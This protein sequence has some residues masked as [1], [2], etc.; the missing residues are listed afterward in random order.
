[1]KYPL[2]SVSEIRSRLQSISDCISGDP[3]HNQR[4]MGDFPH[5]ILN[6]PKIK[7]SIDPTEVLIRNQ[8]SEPI[9][10]FFELSP[11]ANVSDIKRY[12]SDKAGG[13][14]ETLFKIMG[15]D[16]LGW[17][18]PFHNITAQHGIYISSAGCIKLALQA[19]KKPILN[20][21]VED[22]KLK[23]DLAFNAIRR[24]E[25]FHFGFECAIANWE[26]VFEKPIYNRSQKILKSELGYS[27]QEEGLANAYMLRGFRWPP[28]RSR[29]DKVYKEL[30]D[31]V[32]RSPEGYKDGILSVNSFFYWE[33]VRYHAVDSIEKGLEK[34]FSSEHIFPPNLFF[35]DA[36]KIN[37]SRCPII[38]VDEH[39]IFS[40][41]GITVKFI[42]NLESIERSK[43]FQKCLN[44]L[45]R[46]VAAGW[47]KVESSLRY[48]TRIRGLDFKPWPARGKGWFSVRIDRSTRAHLRQDDQ[49]G[50]WIAE[51]IGSHDEMG[52]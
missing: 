46:R 18:F 14:F 23:I 28:N 31:W 16:A 4:G 21:P 6:M 51:E 19:F 7:V 8:E 35:Q 20:D 26:F 52:H 24:H 29:G 38:V 47:E 5:H 15:T 2:S 36:N 39:N 13:D 22:F 40:L 45:D 9:P 43:Y 37:D 1:L 12:L 41:F 11:K 17:Y 42:A 10:A 3:I 44:R 30:F 49:S 32:K 27:R 34:N 50:I 48:S 25:A 33:D